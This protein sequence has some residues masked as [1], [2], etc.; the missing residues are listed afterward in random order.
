M[1]KKLLLL[2]IR[3]YQRCISPAMA[4]RCRYIPTCSRYAVEAVTRFGALKGGYLAAR[5]LLRCHPL[6]HHPLYDPVPEEFS[7]FKRKK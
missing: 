2:L 3:F 6:S 4:P 5:R 7:F 1:A